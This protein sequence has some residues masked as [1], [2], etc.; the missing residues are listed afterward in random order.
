M[1][2]SFLTIAIPIDEDN[3]VTTNAALDAMGNPASKAIRDAMREDLQIHFVS[4]GAIS[5]DGAAKGHLV[6]EASSDASPGDTIQLLLTRLDPWL[7][8][9]FAAAGLPVSNLARLLGGHI[10]TSGTRLRDNAGLDFTGTPGMTVK[11]IRREYDLARK[12]RTL[13]DDKAYKGSAV[14]VLA[15]VRADVEQD[16]KLAP[17]LTLEPAPFLI[18]TKE[19]S[20]L[21]SAPALIGGAIVRF[22]W[23]LLLVCLLLALAAVAAAFYWSGWVSA[24]LTLLVAAGVV[25]VVL[26][27]RLVSI[28]GNLTALEAA[29]V[30]DDSIPDPA[31]LTEVVRRENKVMQNHMTGV[32]R[33]KP[34]RLRRFTLKLAFYVIGTLSARFRPGYL[35]DIGTINFARWVVL[36]GTDQLI[37]FSNY[38]GSW[39]S[40]LEDFVTKA[41]EGLTGIWSN[42]EGYPKTSTLFFEGATAA[43]P[44]LRWARRQHRPTYFWYSGYPHLTTDR[45]R[46]NAAIRQGLAGAK[47]EDEAKAWLANLGS[48]M[49]PPSALD[50]PEIQTIVFGGLKHHPFAA[51]LILSL[52]GDA[53]AARAWLGATSA[54]VTFGDQPDPDNVTLL[55]LSASG[56]RKLGL[57]D[58]QLASF[59]FAFRMGMADPIRSNIL[60]D[61]GD[62]KPAEW[63]WGGDNA[64]DASLLLYAA[65]EAKLTAAIEAAAE[66][67]AEAG[68]SVVHQVGFRPLEEDAQA[69]G[70]GRR[71]QAREAFGFADGVSQ[72]IIKGTRRW[73]KD[74]DAI[75]TVEP[76]EFILGYPDDRGG[77]VFSPLVES[78]KDPKN[79]LPVV[80]PVYASY[81]YPNYDQSGADRARDLGKNGS[82]LVIRQLA[83]DVAAF[84]ESVKDAAAQC[85]NDSRLPPGLEDWQ[86]EQWVAAKMVGRWRDGTSLVRYPHRPGSGWN[87]KAP[88]ENGPIPVEPDNGFLLGAEDPVG[89]RCPFGAHVRRTNPRDT[90]T[91]GSMEQLAINNRHRILRMGRRYEAYKHD[92][93]DETE[94]LFF[95]C[96]NSELERQFEFIQQT[97][98][99]AMQFMGVENEVDSILGRGKKKDG[100]TRK[101]ARLTI[102]TPNGPIYLQGLRDV[103]TVRGGGYFFLP[104]KSALAWLSR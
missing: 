57:D 18:E 3:V 89:E 92:G 87:A 35:S 33:I 54:G 36:P 16:P 98:V 88:N 14:G 84:E 15:S 32:S 46:S 28:F 53:A 75:H 48:R 52:P 69:S 21:S 51:S 44:F 6:I 96:L 2:H 99:M 78:D 22:F 49:P 60:S 73:L 63:I 23:P 79:L 64:A 91:P 25:L 8:P 62:D 34:A 26:L 67:I 39:E 24:V 77:H 70:G 81:H 30:Q 4:I 9:V 104:S 45:I 5:G 74:A 58:A 94:G 13:F 20:F 93:A 66:A 65:D 61:T 17:L 50:T 43:E 76:G 41:H 103:V 37:F 72:P 27:A 97:W 95:M 1:T 55:A 59:P 38:G 19:T 80:D 56:L 68:G 90:L 11:R 12:V 42:T 7:Q 71:N 85:A 47:T 10:V 40:Y 100:D 31:V 101:L 102:P 29:D 86:R 82:Y 83:Q